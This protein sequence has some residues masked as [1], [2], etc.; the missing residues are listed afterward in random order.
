MAIL[1]PCWHRVAVPDG[2][3]LA[4]RVHECDHVDSVR[5]DLELPV[6]LDNALNLLGA[7]LTGAMAAAMRL[8]DALV[9]R[10]GL[11]TSDVYRAGD[12]RHPVSCEVGE[13]IGSF[14]I[15]ERTAHEAIVGKNDR[16]LDFR[17]SMLVE[18]AAV[19]MTTMVF[20]RNAWG[21]CYFAV[22]KPFHLAMV[23]R[24]FDR[25]LRQLAVR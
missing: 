13:R 10:L 3:Q 11:K 21:R 16:H 9:G 8:R 20:F 22:V 25:G 19:T 24:T 23:P 15:F 14:T 18:E 4:A 6:T 7:P 1:E 2:S 17:V 12:P 5:F